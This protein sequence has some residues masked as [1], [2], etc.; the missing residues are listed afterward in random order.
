MLHAYVLNG[1]VYRNL[2]LA[3][4]FVSVCVGVHVSAS[5]RE[6]VYW[7]FLSEDLVILHK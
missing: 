2:P 3:S 6:C 1:G 4:M 7:A 5:M